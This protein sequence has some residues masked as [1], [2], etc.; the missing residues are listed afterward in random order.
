MCDTT[1]GDTR[2]NPQ[3]T[4]CWPTDKTKCTRG[5]VSSTDCIIL[6][7]RISGIPMYI[8]TAVFGLQQQLLLPRCCCT[9][10][11]TPTFVANTPR[12]RPLSSNELGP[13][14]Q[15]LG[16]HDKPALPTR[17]DVSPFTIHTYAQ[18]FTNTNFKFTFP[19]M[20]FTTNCLVCD[21][22]RIDVRPF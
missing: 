2:R 6:H 19:L 8:S 12:G 15:P 10:S 14:L 21:D 5:E 3:R 11:L 1:T 13:A 18:I 7:G 9:S 20:L 16:V 22:G 17:I 4:C